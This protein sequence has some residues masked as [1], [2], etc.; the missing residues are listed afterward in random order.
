M[1]SLVE[2]CAHEQWNAEIAGILSNRPNASGIEYCTKLGI[3]V[4]VCDHKAY[5]SRES[6]DAALAAE[7][8][9]LKPT[10]VILAGFMR[11]LSADFVKRYEGRLLNIHP[12]LLPSFPGLHT[13]ERALQAGVKLHG[14]TVHFVTPELDHGPVVMQAA[15]PV[16]TNDT[17]DTLAARVLAQEHVIYPRAVRWFIESNLVIE[18]GIVRT[19]D[20]AAQSLYAGV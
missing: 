1:R 9:Q 18:Q 5:P 2:A 14:A 17:A 13:H 15:V 12:S 16:L 20:G 10:L 6:F 11:V 19:R 3:P 4:K 7:I 8:D